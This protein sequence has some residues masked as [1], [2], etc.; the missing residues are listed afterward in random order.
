MDEQTE[1][2]NLLLE[3]GLEVMKV[4]AEERKGVKE[5]LGGVKGV[6]GFQGVARKS[7]EINDRLDFGFKEIVKELKRLAGEE[8]ESLITKNNDFLK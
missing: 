3:R 7:K 1:R 4:F 2:F 5:E 8:L 6:A